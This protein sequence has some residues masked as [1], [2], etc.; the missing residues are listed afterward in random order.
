MIIYVYYVY[1]NS[2]P[3]KE[4]DAHGGQDIGSADY[5][6]S[7]PRKEADVNLLHMRKR[8][9]HFNSQPRKEADLHSY[10]IN[11]PRKISIHSLARRLTNGNI[12]T[13]AVN[14]FQFTASQGG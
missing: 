8:M 12:S 4:A 2:Q 9:L 1:F 14:T 10:Y 11:I 5:F 3:R 6:N 7:Q 13:D